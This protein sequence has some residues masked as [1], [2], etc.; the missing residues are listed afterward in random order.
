MSEHVKPTGAGHLRRKDKAMDAEGARELLEKAEV[1][2]LAV[3]LDDGRP[4]A[5]PVNF[6][7]LGDRV[8]IHCARQGAKIDAIRRQ[9]GVC[10]SVFDAG[11]IVG[12]ATAC[13]LSYVYRSVVA[14]GRATIVDDTGRKMEAL[15]ALAR[16]YAPETSGT[17]SRAATEKTLVIEVSMDIVTGKRSH[18]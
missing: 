6:A 9:A 12:A 8:V 10:F 7:V 15:E 17:V 13:E 3:V 11:G 14:F 18:G 1:G 2:T 16:K 4:Y 5:I